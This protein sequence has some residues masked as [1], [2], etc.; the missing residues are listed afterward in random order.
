M[1][2][3]D[4][5]YYETDPKIS[6]QYVAVPSSSGTQPNFSLLDLGTYP[7][8]D[9]HFIKIGTLTRFVT[10]IYLEADNKYYQIYYYTIFFDNTN[11]SISFNFTFISDPTNGGTFPA[12]FKINSLI[13]SCSGNLYDKK[14][15]VVLEPLDNQPKTRI[16]TVTLD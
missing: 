11:D 13:T 8:Y 3:Q 16:L 4:Y 14:G 6:N 1:T 7:L 15:K 10:D 5:Y 12:G 2:I 9:N